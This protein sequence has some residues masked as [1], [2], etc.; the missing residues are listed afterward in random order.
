MK[1]CVHDLSVEQSH[2]A[3]SRHFL[4]LRYINSDPA[5]N[6]L[7]ADAAKARREST[8]T[9]ETGNTGATDLSASGIAAK[10][11]IGCAANSRLAAHSVQTRF[12]KRAREEDRKPRTLA[13]SSN[14]GC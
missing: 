5:D 1:S 13:R 12:R 14:R 3:E 10:G 8:S 4:S 11:S 9:W 2:D 7:G 6:A